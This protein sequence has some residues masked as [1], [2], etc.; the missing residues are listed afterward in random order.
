MKLDC[1]SEHPSNLSMLIKYREIKTKVRIIS[2]ILQL[3]TPAKEQCF[4]PSSIQP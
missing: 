4:M 3:K 1:R 2:I